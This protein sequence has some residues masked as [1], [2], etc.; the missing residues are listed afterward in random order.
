MKVS[1]S[2]P[3]YSI[4][5]N[6]RDNH[7]LLRNGYVKLSVLTEDEVSVFKTLYK[8]WHPTPPDEFYKSY[9]SSNEEYKHEVEQAILKYC[10]PK[11][12][13]YFV[14]FEPFGAMFVVKPSGD[15]GHIPP[16]QDWSFV[17]ET[18]HWS[19]NM[20]LP[21]Q[22]TDERS[23]TM[24]F[25]QGSHFFME[26]IRG[27][28]TP[29]LY[30]HL[31]DAIE[32]HLVDVPLKAGE[33]VFFYHGNVHCSHYNNMPNERVCLGLSLVQKNAPIFFHLLK[34]GEPLP[35]KYEVNTEFFIHYAHNRG[36]I[37]S[38]AKHMGKDHRGFSRLSV[39]ELN[40]RISL[41]KQQMDE[42]TTEL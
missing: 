24:R 6:V 19:L 3:S 17:D 31:Q 29:E 32:P 12:E 13:E 21:I 14:D 9:F 36:K 16:H 38:D 41:T 23:G 8:K 34:N 5:K 26:S 40:E 15:K 10:L 39:N 1:I 2:P 22:D 35:D 37:P 18:Q 27:A 4:L 28:N 20:W 11:I 33:A 7:F 42:F 25:L 30:A